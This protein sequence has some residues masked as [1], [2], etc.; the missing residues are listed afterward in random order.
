M[1]GTGL[2]LRTRAKRALLALAMIAVVAAGTT[3]VSAEEVPSPAGRAIDVLGLVVKSSERSL[4]IAPL[5]GSAEVMALWELPL[6]IPKGLKASAPNGSP[7][8][9]NRI[10]RSTVVRV[11]LT[12]N[13]SQNTGSSGCDLLP[14]SG[15]FGS[16]LV[17]TH[18]TPM[19]RYEGTVTAVTVVEGACKY[20]DMSLGGWG[21]T[22][23][24]IVCRWNDSGTPNYSV[25]VNTRT[26]A[27]GE[28]VISA[29]GAGEVR[30]TPA[31][32]GAPTVT[33]RFVVAG[34]FA[35]AIA[36]GSTIAPR[37]RIRVDIR[38]DGPHD[39]KPVKDY[40][41]ARSLKL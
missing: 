24:A 41:I 27:H 13:V 14:V 1:T 35:W 22:V 6:T 20:D 33:A 23:L 19:P 21:E 8:S 32:K 2:T 39:G 30:I 11:H 12:G 36:P 9:L 16:P 15:G 31:V 10:R 29:L 28:D 4:T 3:S 25:V 5:T 37:T 7:I 38:C 26:A 34:E 40:P 18:P 17:C